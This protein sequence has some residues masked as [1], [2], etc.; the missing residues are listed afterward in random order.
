MIK[1]RLRTGI[2]RNLPSSLRIFGYTLIIVFLLLVFL[3]A[4]ALGNINNGDSNNLVEG[5][6]FA[7]QCFKRGNFWGCG[8][9][10]GGHSSVFPYPMLQYLPAAL[11]LIFAEKA[12]VVYYLSSL[13]FVSFVLILLISSLTFRQKPKSAAIFLFAMMASTLPYHSTASFGEPLAALM[14]LAFAVCSVNSMSRGAMIF[15][16]L[17]A[18]TKET[19]FPFLVVIG[20]FA[21]SKDLDRSSKKILLFRIYLSV[22]VGVIMN[23]LFNVFRF[24]NL[25]NTMY[26]S[27]E[28]VTDGVLR[29]IS[30]A[31]GQYG[32]P[33]F[34]IFAFWPVSSV[35]F[36]AAL[37]SRHRLQNGSVAIREK[38]LLLGLHGG[39][40]MS[41]AL[42]YSPFGWIAVG[43]RLAVPLLP[44]ITYLSLIHLNLDEREGGVVSKY[45]WISLVPGAL[46]AP[47]LLQAPWTWGRAVTTSVTPNEDCPAGFI[48]TAIQTAR[49]QYYSCADNLMF[50][51]NDLPIFSLWNGGLSVSGFAWVLAWLGI[52]SLLASAWLKRDET[53]II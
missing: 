13:N 50:R 27:P 34:G 15:G 30:W 40:A 16:F 28:F 24:G 44:A 17:A 4:R 7:T 35:I 21:L 36:L 6:S 41:L 23:V 22:F 38:V 9:L 20:L 43:P 19:A 42:W 48:N 8:L 18:L 25:R 33:S 53:L 3:D 37:V 2:Q 51:S 46:L 31:F 47:F 5:A 11:L 49:E 10:D 52:A 14:I 45:L 12:Q 29:I 26:A 32:S 1:E 39:L